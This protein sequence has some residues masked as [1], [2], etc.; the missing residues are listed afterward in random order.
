M[1]FHV[2]AWR[3]IVSVFFVACGLLFSE[4]VL[5]RV[6]GQD[7][8]VTAAETSA[9]PG[10][11]VS[12]QSISIDAAGL[13]PLKLRQPATI[14]FTEASLNEVAQW[15]QSQ[16]GL[17]VTLDQRSLAEVDVDENSPV[18]DKLRDQ[19][20]YLLLDRLAQQRIGWRLDGGVLRLYGLG[21]SSMLHNLQYNV[22]DL[23][24][25]KFQPEDLEEVILRVVE[26]GSGW[27]GQD[28]V[29]E[30]DLIFLGDVLFIRQDARTHR[31]IAGLLAALRE[32]ARRGLVDDPAENAAI[33]QALGRQISVQ[34]KAKPLAAVVAELAEKAGVDLRLD[35]S[36]LGSSKVTERT[37]VTFELNEQSLQTTLDLLLGQIGLSWILRDGVLWMTP[38]D[39]SDRFLKTAVFD[40]RDICPNAPASDALSDALKQQVDSRS[41]A[42]K[43]GAGQ[44][45]F[46]KP[47]VMV[48]RQSEL[49]LDAVEELLGNYRVALK[50]SKR[51]ISEDQDPEVVVT[52]YYRLPAEVAAEM[53]KVLTELVAPESWKSDIRPE[54]VGTIRKVRSWSEISETKGAE[55]ILIPQAT[56]IV[57]QKRK[58]HEEVAKFM[59]NV[60]QGTG[61]PG[62]FGGGG[63][64]GGGMGG[65]MPSAGGI[66]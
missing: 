12:D 26:A 4:F 31:R 47:G 32:P 56:L 53:E 19:P 2:R 18:S 39:A 35:V 34:F 8:P 28:D 30:G 22:G 59:D 48:V 15:L 9:T 52:K 14:T 57:T 64:G 6:S 42:D 21:D 62:G 5:G 44:I 49:R 1:L 37:P 33:R 3:T 13:V 50:N 29:A 27:A 61:Q 40:V 38:H 65:A 24:D 20:I 58:V 16:T 55:A 10:F 25:Q 66:F 45:V 54:A 36:A 41:W 11:K 7:T 17:N 51:R 60:K 63:F 46:A 43:D 23:L